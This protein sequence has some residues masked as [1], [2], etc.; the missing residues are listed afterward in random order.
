MG[1]S[2]ADKKQ[3][4]ILKQGVEVWNRWRKENPDVRIDLSGAKLV[5]AD[6]KNII[7]REGKLRVY[8]NLRFDIVDLLIGSAEQ[9][10]M[11]LIRFLRLLVAHLDFPVKMPV[12]PTHCIFR[13]RS[14]ADC[15]F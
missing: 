6:L 15:V 2:M 11:V 10:R 8:G 14:H 1:D 5:R 13:L 4:K 7:L 9:G 3:L 12:H